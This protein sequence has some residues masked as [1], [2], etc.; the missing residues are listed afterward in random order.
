VGSYPLQRN[1][2]R[3]AAAVLLATLALTAQH[4]AARERVLLDA[5]WQFT[6][7]F[8]FDGDSAPPPPT[9]DNFDP[10]LART[11]HLPHDWSIEGVPAADAPSGGAGGYFP[12]G[13]G[14]YRRTFT[15][16]VAWNDQ[17]VTIQFEGVYH[18]CQVWLN[19]QPIGDH[20]YGYT[21]FEIDVTRR[22]KPAGEPNVLAVRVDNSAQPNCRWYSG[23]GIYRHV[24][25]EA[26]SKVY[27]ERD[28]LIVGFKD[29]TTENASLIVVTG[30]G[31]TSDVSRPANLDRNTPWFETEAELFDS[32]GQ[33]VA[34]ASGVAVN[35]L[36]VRR[37]QLWFPDAPTLYSLVTRLI[38]EGRAVDEMTTPI[39]IR[40]VKVTPERGFELNGQ[41]L[42][43]FGG[44]VHHDNGPLGAAAFDRAEAR[45]VE[46]LKAAGFNA[47]RTS[48]NPPSTAFLDACDRLGM[49]VID[50]A[51]DGWAK[52][53]VKHGYHEDFEGNWKADVEAMVRRDRNHPSVV[54]WSIGNEMYERGEASGAK[55]AADMRAAVVALD[56]TRP[57]TAACNGLGSDDKWP[58]IDPVFASLDVAGYNYEL[59]RIE[60]DHERL[61]NRVIQI[62]ESF[63]SEAFAAWDLVQKHPY[64][65]GEF[66]WTA[67]D[68]LGEAGIGRT[69]PPGEKVRHHWEGEHFPWIGAYCGD[70]DVT[71]FRKP[72]SHYRNIIWDRGE[73]LYAA[74]R[75]P[76]PAAGEW[77][78]TL[79]SL[80]PE[81]ASWTWPGREGEEL[82]IVV[83]SR[84]DWAR[85]FLND[86]F[87]GE[88][89][90][91]RDSKFQTVFRV[92]YQPGRVRI[93]V[94]D[95]PAG[96]QSD[97]HDAI[98]SFWLFTAGTPTK[99]RLTA[100][101][102]ELTA[103]GQDL[104]FITSEITDDAGWLNPT[105]LK[106]KYTVTGPATIAA[107]GSGNLWDAVPYNANP[108]AHFEG[109]SLVILRTTGEPGEITLTA[110]A[111]G[112][113]PS[114][115]TL[116]SAAPK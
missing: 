56:A 46:L 88:Q 76:P 31:H 8:E 38:V 36:E 43:L 89:Q 109:R 64:L 104:A 86:K 59:D 84:C 10:A 113:T 62:T 33:S 28:N 78:L 108:R 107:I 2:R 68:Y 110:E 74:V 87:I 95:T 52:E 29:V 66:L 26:T 12:T 101:R 45:R 50:E 18:R 39:G 55:I 27:L 20:A 48:H 32:A 30:V 44:C 34:R 19:G 114:T 82:E 23:S 65:I 70:I 94:S 58:G 49:L 111:E 51:F 25:L 93:D 90:I 41:P 21:P 67:M 57:I 61:P 16:P 37:P 73:M 80:P 6:Q 77:G 11:V 98:T 53:K 60:L 22:L 83:Y 116:K 115:I 85:L 75:V 69:F 35:S 42:K 71:G 100:D 17:R 24:W 106:A 47:I 96:P 102:T 99:L 91:S 81:I 13:R 15:T 92:P 5:D 1:A 14:W 97:E 3:I 72:I 7:L 103:D 63:Q 4:A 79:W 112:L 105:D 40:T 9:Q 54:M